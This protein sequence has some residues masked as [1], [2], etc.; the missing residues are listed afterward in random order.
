MAQGSI[1][2][3]RLSDGSTRYDVVIDLGI[4]PAT[5]RRRQR[6]TTFT[7]K[8]EAQAALAA[9]LADIE[10]GVAV[11]RSRQT[12][13]DTLRY[14]LDTYV[15]PNLRPRTVATYAE[16]IDHHLIPGLGGIRLQSLTASQVQAFYSK[17]LANG[18][19]LCT[20]AT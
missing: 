4:D 16:V 7:I 20:I 13:A 15:R 18:V 10:R 9:W 8:R 5:N 3:R 12:V 6:K 2:K 14:W 1:K 19:G 11:D 17:L